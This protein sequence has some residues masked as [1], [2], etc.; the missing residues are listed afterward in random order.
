MDSKRAVVSSS[1]GI[2]L[3]F[4]PVARISFKIILPT[5]SSSIRLFGQRYRSSS[6]R[7]LS[8]PTDT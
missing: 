2:L 8:S 3:I 7:I 1:S 6:G 4:V 5:V